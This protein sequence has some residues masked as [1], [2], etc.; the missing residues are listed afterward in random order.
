MAG[1]GSSELRDL[2]ARVGRLEGGTC[3]DVSSLQAEVKSALES[4]AD[5][6][7]AV[8]DLR[9]AV[10]DLRAEV[11]RLRAEVDELLAAQPAKPSAVAEALAGVE[12]APRRSS[13]KSAKGKR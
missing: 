10:F 8:F 12:A 3:L 7:T 2:Q 11:K 13:S 9:T 5:V 4:C 1:G 6:W